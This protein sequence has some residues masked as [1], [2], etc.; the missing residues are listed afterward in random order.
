MVYNTLL[1]ACA[2]SGEVHRATAW[3]RR[4]TS[5]SIRVNHKTFGKVIEAAAKCGCIK[6]ARA[7]FD[8]M[9]KEYGSNTI[10][11]NI[12]IDACAKASCS[13]EAAWWLDRMAHVKVIAD[14]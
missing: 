9:A 1:K 5:E 6:S 3:Y 7:W 14:S 10:A 4:M 13:Q 8:V 2:N 11:F 12:V